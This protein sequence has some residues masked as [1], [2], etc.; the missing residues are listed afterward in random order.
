MMCGL[1]RMCGTLKTS[2]TVHTSLIYTIDKDVWTVEDV[3][4]SQNIP[5]SK[6]ESGGFLSS[7]FGKSDQ[8]LQVENT[9]LSQQL[10]ESQQARKEAERSHQQ[11]IQLLN[12]TLQETQSQLKESDTRLQET[13]VQLQLAQQNFQDSQRQIQVFISD[14]Y[15]HMK[16]A[17]IL[18]QIGY[19][20]IIVLFT[21]F[22]KVIMFFHFKA[23]I[24]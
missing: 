9:I 5:K 1:W 23:I 4:N 7:V 20:F 19:I 6:Q 21:F 24:I 18:L 15:M 14:V 13:R 11:E 10:T 3:W 8:S 16:H 22:K 2:S 12:T 17:V